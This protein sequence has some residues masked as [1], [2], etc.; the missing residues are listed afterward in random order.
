MIVDNPQ[1]EQATTLVR[2]L[3]AAE[4]LF[5]RYSERNPAHF[6]IV[7][8]FDQV[9]H[10]DKVRTAVAAVQRRHP[11]LSVHVEDRPDTRLGFYRAATVA[12]VALTA[13]RGPELAWQAAA[14]EELSRP[15]DRSRA[16]LMRAALT[17]GS[18]AQ[19]AAAHLRPHDRRRNQLHRRAHRRDC[20]A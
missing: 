6:S 18:G 19:R 15:F 3:G 7:A 5:Y 11:L 2:P 20:C 10:A 12:R 1:D 16:P 8:E 4:R 13:R 9:L 14:A 17:A